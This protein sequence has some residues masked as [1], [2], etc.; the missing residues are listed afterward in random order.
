M[1]VNGERERSIL[2]KIFLELEIDVTSFHHRFLRQFWKL[3]PNKH[4]SLNACKITWRESDELERRYSRDT[5][6]RYWQNEKSWNQATSWLSVVRFEKYEYIMIVIDI[7]H[8]LLC[9]RLQFP[10]SPLCL[11]HLILSSFF[12]LTLSDPAPIKFVNVYVPLLVLRMWYHDD[13]EPPFFEV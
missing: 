12:D 4:V 11:S 2:I 7:F 9:Y 1:K 6:E 3:E 5:S 13:K 10:P 8:R